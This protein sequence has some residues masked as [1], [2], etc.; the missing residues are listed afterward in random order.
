MTGAPSLNWYVEMG[1]NHRGD[2]PVGVARTVKAVGRES[3][4]ATSG[5]GS[6]TQCCE[7]KNPGVGSTILCAVF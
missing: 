7:A 6:E 4:V 2:S 5:H 1:D 3:C